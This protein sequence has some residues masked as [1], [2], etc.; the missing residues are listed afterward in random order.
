M[1]AGVRQA[2]R[3]ERQPLHR[4]PGQRVPAA[5][6]HQGGVRRGRHGPQQRQHAHEAPGTGM[7]ISRLYKHINRLYKH[8]SQHAEAVTARNNVDMLVKREAR[9][10]A[11]LLFVPANCYYLRALL[12]AP[13]SCA[14]RKPSTLRSRG[15][16]H[17]P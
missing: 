15:A 11:A 9:A 5:A 2:V 3:V 4:Q 1:G 8:Q 10:C 7:D 6:G 12:L 16:G 17:A 14:Q 13:A